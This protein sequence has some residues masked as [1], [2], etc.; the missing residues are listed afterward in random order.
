[1][2]QHWAAM[3]NMVGS[4]F[5]PTSFNAGLRTQV[6]LIP[7]DLARF[8]LNKAADEAADAKR[9]QA[10]NAAADFVKAMQQQQAKL[11]AERKRSG[12]GG[13]PIG[14]P[15]ARPPDDF[16]RN[17]ERD[18]RARAGRGETE[19][20]GLVKVLDLA[21]AGDRDAQAAI[22]QLLWEGGGFGL[23]SDR[24]RA[25][26]WLNLAAQNTMPPPFRPAQDADT[27]R[28]SASAPSLKS[29]HQPPTTAPPYIRAGFYDIAIDSGGLAAPGLSV[30]IITAQLNPNG[31]FSGT[32][33]F[34][35]GA[36]D[37]LEGLGNMGGVFGDFIP[38]INKISANIPVTGSYVFEPRGNTLNLFYAG[39]KLGQPLSLQLLANFESYTSEGDWLGMTKES[40]QVRVRRRGD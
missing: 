24:A 16:D 33:K 40:V 15:V 29:T 32:L 17:L 38:F 5:A 35:G 2:S 12:E 39:S 13:S 22:G 4:Q 27:H 23:K 1:M 34:S 6:P 25:G 11:D 10:P 9:A 8:I 7:R 18:M 36:R 30:Q 20:R 14:T 28:A 26:H 21:R 31:S 3:A 37:T 19:M